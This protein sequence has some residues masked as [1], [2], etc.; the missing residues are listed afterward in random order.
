MAIYSRYA[1]V[2]ESDGSRMLVR[3]AL[4]LINQA[5]DQVLTEQEGEFDADTRWA[6]TWFEQ[7]GHEDGPYGVAETL[8]KA[9]S[10]SVRGLDEPGII[11]ARGSKVR[12]LRRDELPDDWDP[13]TDRRLAIWEA[14]QHLI[15]TLEQKGESAAAALL[16]KL[17]GSLAD[18]ARDLAYRLYTHLR[19]EEMGARGVDL[20]WTHLGLA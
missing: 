9:K 7:H 4:Q 5:L 3:T 8:S 14:T 20:Q 16:E 10:V 18:T 17:G 1:K 6:I 13:M 11:K 2:M 19:T 15:R 12:L